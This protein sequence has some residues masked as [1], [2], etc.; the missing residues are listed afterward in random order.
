MKIIV[1][2][3]AA[4]GALAYAISTHAATFADSDTVSVKVSVA[5]LDLGSQA[6]AAVALR[7]INNAAKIVCGDEPP[8][9]D[10]DRGGDYHTCMT[11]TVGRTVDSLGNPIVSALNGGHR[12]LATFL[13][14][15]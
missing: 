11:T 13:A 14:S 7:R 2:T 9:R 5:D 12:E 3:V 10:M 6:G 8:I 4:M 1:T 15:R